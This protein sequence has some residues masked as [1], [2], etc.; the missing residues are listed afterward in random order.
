MTEDAKPSESAGR[1]FLNRLQDLKKYRLWLGDLLK[2][3]KDQTLED[4]QQAFALESP[5]DPERM[6]HVAAAAKDLLAEKAKAIHQGAQY[7]DDPNARRR[8]EAEARK[9]K[10]KAQQADDFAQRFAA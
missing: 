9:V 5:I 8:E 1:E 2:S 10:A 4:F 3:I 7:A 6:A